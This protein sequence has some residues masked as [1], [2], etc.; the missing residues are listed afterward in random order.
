MI[1][2]TTR[3]VGGVAL[4]TA[5]FTLAAGPVAAGTD[6]TVSVTAV[7]TGTG[8]FAFQGAPT[9]LDAGKYEVG[10]TNTSFAPHE[11]V[12]F[13]LAEEHEDITLTQLAAAADANDDSV[14]DK[15][16]GAVFAPPGSSDIGKLKV[17]QSGTYAYFCFIRPEGGPPSSA[18]YN[19][20]LI[21]KFAVSE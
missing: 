14:V 2:R 4:A 7:D 18:H 8:Q 16:A 9:T 15:F 19:R 10:L 11:F 3:F 1:R 5:A 20:G 17:K 13:K 12:V 21:G 6:G